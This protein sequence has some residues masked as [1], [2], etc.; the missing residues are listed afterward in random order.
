MHDAH[1]SMDHSPVFSLESG[2]TTV[3]GLRSERGG[4][5]SFGNTD[6]RMGSRAPVSRE[7]ISEGRGR[8]LNR[9][10]MFSNTK[11]TNVPS[12][13]KIIGSY[14]IISKSI[15]NATVIRFCTLERTYC[16]PKILL[17]L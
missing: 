14:S 2:D 12:G 5:K 3:Q 10:Y 7:T 9:G 8:V 16:R 4:S 11:T 17:L 6:S 15:F 13:P 1:G